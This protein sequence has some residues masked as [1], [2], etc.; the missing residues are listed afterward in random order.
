MFVLAFLFF[1]KN[2]QNLFKSFRH[3]KTAHLKVI[4]LSF[5]TEGF[6]V[7]PINIATCIRISNLGMRP[8][9][10]ARQQACFQ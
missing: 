1:M 3:L 6:K 4:K 2:D 9:G 7:F 5:L 10:K 8:L